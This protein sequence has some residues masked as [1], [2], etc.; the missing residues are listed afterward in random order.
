MVGGVGRR[1][2]IVGTPQR[3]PA[4]VRR[5]PPPVT[6]V[7]PNEVKWNLH[8]GG[9]RGTFQPRDEVTRKK[10]V[11]TRDTDKM[12]SRIDDRFARLNQ[13]YGDKG[14]GLTA[15]PVEAKH[16]TF[17]KALKKVVA[18]IPA[19]IIK[20]AVT[21]L[22]WTGKLTVN[23][24]KYTARAIL[25][26]FRKAGSD[27]AR[28]M[29]TFV[30]NLGKSINKT[31][32]KLGKGAT[33]G[34]DKLFGLKSGEGDDVDQNREA[35]V[36]SANDAA[37]QMMG[38]VDGL[39]GYYGTNIIDPNDL[40]NTLNDQAVQESYPTTGNNGDHA[41]DMGAAF[42]VAGF[43]ETADQIAESHAKR[44]EGQHLL[45]I[46]HMLEDQGQTMG[47]PDLVTA[48]RFAQQLGVQ[49][50]SQGTARMMEGFVNAARLGVGGVNLVAGSTR[51][52][53]QAFGEFATEVANVTQLGGDALTAVVATTEC[54]VDSA[55]S[56]RSMQ[57]VDR[58]NAFL[59]STASVKPSGKKTAQTKDVIAV[60]DTVKLFKKNQK[61]VR[62][63]KIFT[64]VRNAV[65]AAGAVALIVGATAALACTPVGWAVA[66]AAITTGIGIGVYKAYKA[67]RRK[68]NISALKQRQNQ[69]Q[70]AIQNLESKG[71]LD[72][73]ERRMLRD[74]KSLKASVDK[75]LN[76]TDPAAAVETL[77]R[78]LNHSDSAEGR[79]AAKIALR[80]VF[81]VNPEVLRHK[82]DGNP[83]MPHVYQEACSILTEKMGIFYASALS[84]N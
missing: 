73:T 77:V 19:S 33:D 16:K 35:N 81:Q 76:Q 10:L 66:G 68:A 43:G 23:I 54:I 21:L 64:A 61:Q 56:H 39:A 57:R 38:V 83:V 55:Q 3:G 70:R 1:N 40:N 12:L 24:L 20:G 27:S 14:L 58:C 52:G 36:N 7:N 28:D 8:T 78:V 17:F 4:P 32:D 41:L 31:L 80:D 74:L 25:F 13:K 84:S 2:A 82:P 30:A 48:G 46:G 65:I 50:E 15:E 75:S 11:G 44:K 60:R 53:S 59:E 22:K 67:G 63:H 49:K 37:N 72:G 51:Y 6:P 79:E 26:P 47:D 45:E 62:K 69:V 34:V 9:L 71:Q 29:D 42:V 18:A 5:P